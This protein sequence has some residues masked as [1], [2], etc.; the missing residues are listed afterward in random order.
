MV[1]AVAEVEEA[2]EVPKPRGEVDGRKAQLI[3]L[4][5]R[6]QPCGRP[7]ALEMNPRGG[8]LIGGCV[9]ATNQMRQFPGYANAVFSDQQRSVKGTVEGWEKFR[10][11]KNNISV[12]QPRHLAAMP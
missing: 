10:E 1:S 2:S 12:A 9:P 8:F 4:C 5:R 11:E 6:I 7:L 3:R